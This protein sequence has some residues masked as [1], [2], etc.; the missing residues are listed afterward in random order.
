MTGHQ[1]PKIHNN[2]SMF[3]S[4]KPCIIS[5]ESIA[6]KCTGH[7]E[8]RFFR[9]TLQ[10]FLVQQNWFNP[11]P[12]ECSKFKPQEGW[13]WGEIQTYVN[14]GFSE[15][16]RTYW[17]EFSHGIYCFLLIIWWRAG[18]WTWM[19]CFY[20]RTLLR[21]LTCLR[22]SN[23]TINSNMYLKRKRRIDAHWVK[24]LTTKAAKLVMWLHSQ[25]IVSLTM[26]RREH[27]AVDQPPTDKNIHTTFIQH[28]YNVIKTLGSSSF[29]IALLYPDSRFWSNNVSRNTN[30][31]T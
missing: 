12:T 2:T 7:S 4:N 25:I 6:S 18:Q 30:S 26:P 21:D 3:T 23:V 22:T 8:W 20:Y 5:A 9:F 10:L 27:P 28:S 11:S 24:L 17:N 29:T 31:Q 14:N 19:A 1:Y 13:W 15:A 16:F